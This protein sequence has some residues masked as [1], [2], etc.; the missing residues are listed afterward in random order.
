MNVFSH[1]CNELLKA[2]LYKIDL[3]LYKFGETKVE[4]LRFRKKVAKPFVALP[5]DG[6][7]NIYR[8]DAHL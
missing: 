5:T 4:Y 1:V 6:G 7:Q 8:I 2:I 3:V